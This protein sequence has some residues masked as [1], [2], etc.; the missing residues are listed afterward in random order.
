VGGCGCV[1]VRV[2]V[3]AGKLILRLTTPNLNDHA[4]HNKQKGSVYMVF[5]YAETDL[6]GVPKRAVTI[7]KRNLRPPLLSTTEIR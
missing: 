4:D 5:E 1:G 6:A 7:S 3:C 2:R